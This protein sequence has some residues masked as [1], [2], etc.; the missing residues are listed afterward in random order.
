[1]NSD[2][3]IVSKILTSRL[4]PQMNTLIYKDQQCAAKGR[5]I[6][7]QHLHNIRD[8]ITY[9]GDKQ[10]KAYILSI[11]QEKAFDR[12]DHNFLRVVLKEC[13]LGKYFRDWVQIMYDNP[14]SRVLIN[15]NLTEEI[16]IERSV[17]QGCS[18][19]PLLYTLA[20]EPVLQEIRERE[21]IKGVKLQVSK[22]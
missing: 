6:H 7:T 16:N 2:Y 20:L 10:T 13:Y 21:N 14:T 4:K 18:L 22:R 5:K 9:C 3:K 19:S 1:M 11:D 15:Q 12:V 17:R 8:L